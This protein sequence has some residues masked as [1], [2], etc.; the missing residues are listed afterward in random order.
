MKKSIVNHATLSELN[1]RYS[2]ESQNVRF[3]LMLNTTFVNVGL[4]A[5][6]PM[7]EQFARLGIKRF[8]LFDHDTA[9]L[10]NALSQSYTG[11]DDGLKKEEATKRK[12]KA[13]EF[14]KGNPNIPPSE[15][16]TYGDFLNITDADI[17]KI[18][19]FE[20]QNN[21]EIV[22]VITT[23]YH[24]PDARA[25]RIALK[26]GVPVF[27]VSLYRMGMAGEII[28]Y[29]PGHGLPCY[30][31]ITETRYNF[32]DKSRRVNHLKGDFSGSGRSAGLPMAASYVDSIL[33]HLIIGYI[34]REIEENQ[35]GRLFRRLLREK[36]NFI[37]CQLDPS[38]RLNGEDI[39]ALINGPDVIT[40][41]TIFQQ[42]SKKSDC[43]DC[44]KFSNGW[45][46][47]H[48]DYTKENYREILERFSELKKIGADGSRYKHP[49]LSE[50]SSLFAIWEKLQR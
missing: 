33:G 20:R 13:R 11:K 23:D 14:E 44:V 25:N 27:W 5:S 31:C 28:F 45:V 21:S 41:N 40:F 16:Y 39:F 34:H 2:R 50:Y 7:I 49:L 9:E 38:Y 3:D 29:V 12:L 46:W 22:F 37:Q 30:R 42:E 26:W 24:P 47:N 6:G 36:R 18:I 32:F 19:Q 10:K 4:G 8:H 1:N 48:T 35:H 43:I 17:E 15:I